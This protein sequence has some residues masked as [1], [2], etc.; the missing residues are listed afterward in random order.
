MYLERAFNASSYF[1]V[2]NIVDA[3]AAHSALSALS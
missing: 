2:S 1:L 3:L